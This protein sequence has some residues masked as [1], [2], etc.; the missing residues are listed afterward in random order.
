MTKIIELLV[1]PLW[2]PEA[3]TAGSF[4]P[5]GLFLQTRWLKWRKMRR[6]DREISD[7]NAINEIIRR[8]KVCRIA[9]C[10]NGQP[11]VLPLNFGY[12]GVHL[13][14]HS[15]KDGKKIEIIK[16]NNRVGFEFDILHK[17]ITA[18]NPCEWGT[19]YESVVG[20]GIAE[21]IESRQEKAK[22]LQCILSQYGGSFN[23]FKDSALSSVTII[24]VTIVSIRG[25]EMK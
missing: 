20:S 6:K 10:E 15:A 17:I 1:R 13:Y 4:N 18:E 11:Y 25:K 8:C 14:F 22:A 21:L 9:F 3:E 12:D 2:Q 7:R 23:E 5:S 16:Q 24:R 19:K